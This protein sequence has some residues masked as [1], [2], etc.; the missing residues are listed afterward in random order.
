LNKFHYTL[1]DII[2]ALFQKNFSLT[3]VIVQKPLQYWG[4]RFEQRITPTIILTS[5][6]SVLHISFEIFIR[7]KAFR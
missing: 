3:V 6:T 2:R 7:L 1:Y 4:V 5:A